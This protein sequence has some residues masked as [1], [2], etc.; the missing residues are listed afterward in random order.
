MEA[1]LDKDEVGPAFFFCKE[2]DAKFLYVKKDI[3]MPPP[4][5]Y[6]HGQARAVQHNCQQYFECS[7]GGWS[8]ISA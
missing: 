1:K 3:Q 6:D 8:S 2:D 5:E 7:T 4:E